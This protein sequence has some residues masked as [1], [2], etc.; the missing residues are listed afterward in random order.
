MSIK[1]IKKSFIY[2]IFIHFEVY[3]FNNKTQDMVE[4]ST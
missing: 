2:L 4:C 1:F 3:G